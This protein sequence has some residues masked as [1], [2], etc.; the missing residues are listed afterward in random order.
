MAP[1]TASTLM[2]KIASS[3]H[4]A[5]YGSGRSLPRT[6]RTAPGPPC[7]LS[8]RAAPPR[9]TGRPPR[10]RPRRDDRGVHEQEAAAVRVRLHPEGQVEQAPDP[11]V[12]RR[13][14][15]GCPAGRTSAR[16]TGAHVLAPLESTRKRRWCQL[17]LSIGC[18]RAAARRVGD[19]PKPSVP[20]RGIDGRTTED[21][22]R[23]WLPRRLPVL[24]DRRLLVARPGLG[25][26]LTR[27]CE[28]PRLLH[29]AVG[30][31]QVPHR[32]EVAV[33][34]VLRSH[35]TPNA[36]NSSSPMPARSACL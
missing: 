11:R 29:D 21:R 4:P 28:L 22:C 3:A 24:G 31:V 32:R 34:V 2:K 18:S 9:G 16:C 25:G 35:R 1:S 19:V 12:G 15:A 36:R 33:L 23:A 20:R 7:D 10:T 26:D 30:G 27:L 13:E 17:I 6:C 14:R 5:S 8:H